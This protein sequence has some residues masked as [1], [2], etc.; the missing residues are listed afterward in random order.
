VLG[1]RVGVDGQREVDVGAG[2][3]RGRPARGQE[4]VAQRPDGLAVGG[5]DPPGAIAVAALSGGL[6]GLASPAK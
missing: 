6:A 1:A 5:D 4:R 2:P 3:L